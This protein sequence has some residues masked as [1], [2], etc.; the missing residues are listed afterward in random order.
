MKASCI[1]KNKILEDENRY[2]EQM[3]TYLS[4]LCRTLKNIIEN[5]L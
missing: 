3:F 5:N 2:F 1:K 4:F